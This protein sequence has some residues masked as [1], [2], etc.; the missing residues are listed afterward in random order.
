MPQA[1]LRA[2]W[3]SFCMPSCSLP[4]RRLR[5]AWLVSQPGACR[6]EEH[7]ED[8]DIDEPLMVP[9]ARGRAGVGLRPRLP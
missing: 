5:A 8:A 3:R 6:L 4:W 1:M 7:A 2:H 9:K